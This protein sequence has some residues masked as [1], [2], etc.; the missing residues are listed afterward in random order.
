[1]TARLATHADASRRA[2]ELV[3]RLVTAGVDVER[4]SDAASGGAPSRD[5]LGQVLDETADLALVGIGALRGATSD[6]L[7]MLATPPREDPRDVLVVLGGSP[8]PL[9]SLPS[10][11]R[12]GVSGPRRSALLL[13]HRPDVIAVPIE[14]KPPR[15]MIEDGARD[16]DAVVVGSVEARR[17][18]LAGRIGEVLDPRSWLPEPGQGIVALMARHPIAEVTAL[19]HLPTR[20][21]LRAELALLDALDAA[22]G[23]ALGSL[24]QPSGRL[25]RLCAAV[26]SPDGRRIARSDQTGPLDE[27]ELLG[28]SVARQLLRRG[29]D[30]VL[31]GAVA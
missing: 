18:G 30:L 5:P 26:V 9:R 6:R 17:G 24:A 27:P 1:M 4:I 28:S 25:V 8:A 11:A 16:L 22:P 13:A 2:D 23:A 10:G 7:T 29:A 3:D 15:E 12:V 19:D 31:S 14:P 20:T 21:A